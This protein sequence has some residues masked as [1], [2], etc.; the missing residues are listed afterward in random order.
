MC[1][2]TVQYYYFESIIQTNY[3][4]KVLTFSL[5]VVDS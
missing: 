1:L 4:V 2:S 3:E 5:K